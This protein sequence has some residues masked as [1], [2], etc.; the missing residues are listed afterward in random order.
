MALSKSVCKGIASLSLVMFYI[1]ISIFFILS[2][3]DYSTPQ[4]SINSSE[5]LNTNLIFGTGTYWVLNLSIPFGFLLIFIITSVLEYFALLKDKNK[6][7]SLFIYMWPQYIQDVWTFIILVISFWVILIGFYVSYER[8]FGYNTNVTMN[9][10]GGFS[11]E[12]TDRYT[13]ITL[14]AIIMDIVMLWFGFDCIYAYIY[15]VYHTIEPTNKMIE[16]IEG[17]IKNP[18]KTTGGYLKVIV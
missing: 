6:T 14:I 18:R 12:M 7:K 13:S 16:K 11:D 1:S 2:I 4:M 10:P 8:K 15:G 5:L 9:P 3:I 17:D